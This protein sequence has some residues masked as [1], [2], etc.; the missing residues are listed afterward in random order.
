MRGKLQGKDNAKFM[1]CHAIFQKRLAMTSE[2]ICH[3]EPF[4][5]S[6]LACHI[7]RMRNIHKEF[8]TNFLN[9]WILRALP[10]SITK[11]KFVRILCRT[12]RYTL[13]FFGT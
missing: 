13:A 3:F 11:N 6:N 4:A 12:K 10:S 1:D 8:K 2:L 9:L 7:E 5:K